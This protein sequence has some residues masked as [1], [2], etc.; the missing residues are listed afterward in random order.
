MSVAKRTPRLVIIG[1]DCAE[2]SLVFDAWHAELPNLARLMAS[3]VYGSLESCVPAITVPAWSCMLSGRDPGELGIYGFRNR[4][5]RTYNRMVVANSSAVKVPR[6]WDIAASAGWRVAVVGVPGTYPP[7]EVNGALVSCFLAPST[8]VVFTHPPELAERIGGWIGAIVHGPAGYLLDVPDFRSE[9]KQRILNDIYAMCNQRFDV[10]AGLLDEEQPDL[11][12]LVDMGV[13]RIQHAL[14]RDMDPRHPKYVPGSPFAGAIQA[15]YRHVD[16]RIGRLLEQVGDDTVV[17]VVSDH[18]ARPLIGGV[19]VNEWLLA[20]GYLALVEAPAGAVSLDAAGV[21]WP[22]T[23]AWGAGGYY[24]RIF[25]NV[26][27]REPQGV[28]A[29]AEYQR[30]RDELAASLRAMPGPDGRPLGNRVFMPQELYRSVRGIAPD[31]IVY[32]GDL[33]WRAVGTVGGGALFTDENDTG[34][35]DANH[36]QHGLLIMVDP[37][38]PGGGRQIE[39]ARIYDVLPTLLARFGITPPAGLRGRVLALA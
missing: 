2:P 28:I 5:D 15:Y 31:L 26:S 13:D 22:R 19:C 35:D 14:W 23:L 1:L 24:G 33:A 11:L 7:P 4:A 9:D 32:F 34:P 36:A 25:L 30:I 21:D 20:H 18:G 29:P 8:N 3:G 6:L 16:A 17:L 27:G 10:A 38:H 39:G 12:M 37:Q